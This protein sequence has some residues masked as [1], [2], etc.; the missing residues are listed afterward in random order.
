MVAL[1]VATPAVRR[2][3]PEN[4]AI[5]DVL[6]LKAARRDAVANLKFF[7]ASGHQRLNFGRFMYIR[8]AAPPYA[9]GTLITV[10]VYG[11]WVKTPV[12][13]FGVCSKFTKFWNTVEDTL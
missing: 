12:L 9:V 7:G 6:P 2:K 3:T 10:S 13:F 11:G 8:Y 5:N 1:F 4:V